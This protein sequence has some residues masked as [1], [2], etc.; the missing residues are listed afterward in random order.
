MSKKPKNPLS[1]KSR[2][3]TGFVKKELVSERM[4]EEKQGLDLNLAIDTADSE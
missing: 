2:L 4:R 3:K 1:T